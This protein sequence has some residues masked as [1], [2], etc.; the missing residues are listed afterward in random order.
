MTNKI[1]EKIKQLRKKANVTQG[2]FADYLGITFQ[3]VSRWESGICYP[4]LE[5][6]PAIANYFGVTTDELL[7]VDIMNKQ[8]KINEIFAQITIN[9]SK[10][11]I[12]ENIAILRNAVNEFPNDCQLLSS[13]AFY[14]GK[15]NETMKEAISINERILED[16]NDDQIRYGVMQKLAYDYKDIGEKEKAIETA[17]KLPSTPVTCDMLLRHILDGEDKITQL[18]SN[19]QSFCDY[20]T[21][22]ITNLA[23]TKYKDDLMKQ[24]ELYTK[25]IDIYKIVYEE[26]DFGFYNGR[27]KDLYIYTASIYMKLNEYDNALDC[28]NQAADY[29]IAFDTMPE[30][31]V[32]TS[33]ISDG[34]EFSKIKNLSKSYDYNDSYE[35]L[36]DRLSQPI[37]DPIREDKRFKAIAAK[38]EKYAA[39]EI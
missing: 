1:G 6:I 10:G 36:N 28:L 26:N 39:K 37:Y 18:R 15:R 31:F 22:D 27:M 3:S 11:F 30:V 38:L 7:G 14:L 19:I 13:L 2:Q 34:D 35:M 17:K 23:R 32:H 9:A 12:D 21:G 24:I 25:A 29:A 4:D 8:E 20:F 5:I 33:I 16:C